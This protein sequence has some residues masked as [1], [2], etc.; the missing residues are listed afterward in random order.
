MLAYFFLGGLLHHDLRLILC[1]LKGT[2]SLFTKSTPLLWDSPL[3]WRVLCTCG[4]FYLYLDIV[5]F[6]K[7]MTSHF[8]RS[9]RLNLGRW[10]TTT[11]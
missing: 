6:I 9:P 4:M 5:S 1:I 11:L 10:R 7:W 8:C 2:L 3:S